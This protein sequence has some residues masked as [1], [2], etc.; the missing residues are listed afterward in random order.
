MLLI[1]C[2]QSNSRFLGHA[3]K[4]ND[5]MLFK[6]KIMQSQKKRVKI[7]YL[8]ILLLIKLTNLQIKNN[9]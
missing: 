1:T 7:H 3:N 9:F 2:T 4:L 5:S 6:N 8:N